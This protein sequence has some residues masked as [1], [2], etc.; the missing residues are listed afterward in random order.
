MNTKRIVF[1]LIFAV[2]IILIVWGL[3][4]AMNKPPKGSSFGIPAPVTLADHIT[5]PANAPVTLIEYSDFQCPACENYYPVVERLLS[6]SSTTLRVVYRQFPLSQHA[7]AMPAAMA[8]EAA[9]AQGKFWEMYRELFSNHTDW[10][11]LT[12]PTDVFVGY[13]TKIGLDIPKFK[14]DL[15]S[16]T[17]RD[18]VN[19]DEQEGISLGINSTP[20]FFVNGKVLVNPEN[21]DQFKAIIDSAAQASVQ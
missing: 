13:A 18:I 2:V 7:N 14:A 21:Y 15:A 11:E 12:N 6:E 10:T 17:L 5:G 8:S 4:V 20:T 16:S 1:W 3:I 19:A 9:G